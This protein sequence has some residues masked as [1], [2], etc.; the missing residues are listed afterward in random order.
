MKKQTITKA[1]LIDLDACR[2]G[3]VRFIQQTD[4]T[5]EPVEI[6]SLIGGKNTYSDL[7]WLAVKLGYQK[8]LTQFSKKCALLNIE[9]IVPYCSEDELQVITAFLSSDS[10]S[11]AAAERA[12]ERAAWAAARAAWAAKR[13]AAEAAWEKINEYLAEVF[14]G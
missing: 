9:L 1:E 5:D 14:R 12:A 8:E 3:L 4:G 6:L 13:A 10:N 11:I 7:C 2:S